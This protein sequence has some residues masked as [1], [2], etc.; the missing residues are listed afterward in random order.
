MKKINKSPCLKERGDIL[1]AEKTKFTPF[2][3][4]YQ[5]TIPLASPNM[6][7]R[8]PINSWVLFRD[9]RRT[10]RIGR[11]MRKA[12]KYRMALLPCKPSFIL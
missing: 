3:L 8:L 12:V 9:P 11:Q 2:I 5:F 10:R 7:E 4:D 6:G 1:Y